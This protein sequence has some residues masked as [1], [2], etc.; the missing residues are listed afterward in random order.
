MRD[1][2]SEWFSPGG[3]KR[4]RQIWNVFGLW[5]NWLCLIHS[6]EHFKVDFRKMSGKTPRTKR[7]ERTTKSTFKQ[8]ALRWRSP[9]FR[10]RAPTTMT[11]RTCP[12]RRKRS[13]PLL[14]ELLDSKSHFQMVSKV[15]LEC[16][17]LPSLKQSKSLA[18]PRF[19]DSR[20]T[21]RRTYKSST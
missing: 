8:T 3:I 17:A 7:T 15:R 11:G 6:F 19:Q 9:T 21:R 14:L 5:K 16:S 1:N 13:T 12:R 10:R 20:M 2:S 4:N 18:R